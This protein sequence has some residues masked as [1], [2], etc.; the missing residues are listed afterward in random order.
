MLT[1]GQLAR[2]RITPLSVDVTL[3]GGQPVRVFAM[4]IPDS[5]T[6]PTLV[7]T[8]TSRRPT[9]TTLHDAI[10]EMLVGG[11][12]LIVLA[13][14]VEWA[15]VGATLKPI[16][17]MRV[18]AEHI[19]GDTATSARLPVGRARD[20][21]ARLGHTFNEL[22]E[23]MQQ[24]LNQQRRF[25][26]DA[27]HELRTPLTML[28]AE[29]ELGARAGRQPEEVQKS[30]RSA[31]ADTDR[32]VR[33]VNSLLAQAT[34]DT[35][36]AK[37]THGPVDLAAAAAEGIDLMNRAH[38]DV[39]IDFEIDHNPPP[40]VGSHDRL[41]QLTVNLIDNAIKASP[42]GGPVQVSVQNTGSSVLLCVRDHGPGFDARF[43]PHAT[44]PFAREHPTETEDRGVGL[45]LA[46]VES[47]ARE[48]AA[49]LQITNPPGGG[50]HVC[51]EFP[52]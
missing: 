25:V 30:L 45:G 2:A 5:G 43:L 38:P 20:E 18:T 14:A 4:A 26:A 40:L 6:P 7:I 28:R 35:A 24:A 32:L 49:T 23:R 22:I 17:R 12:V 9:L 36:A 31:Y 47:I 51:I 1:P 29:L 13:T 39:V 11:T 48:H 41:V 10:I 46:I 42:P 33:L 44:E 21:V 19:S 16:E 50:A 37:A 15:A 34:A 3:A 52:H 27:S 8:G